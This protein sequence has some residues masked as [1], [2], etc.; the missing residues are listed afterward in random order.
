M[1]PAGAWRRY[2]PAALVRAP[3]ACPMTPTVTSASGCPFAADVTLP[4]PSRVCCACALV[5]ASAN[6]HATPTLTNRFTEPPRGDGRVLALS[7]VGLPRHRKAVVRGTVAIVGTS[8][9]C[10]PNIPA[11]HLVVNGRGYEP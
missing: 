8:P 7:V 2:S 10:S 9:W 3:T 1:S 6:R 4:V 11:G 5:A